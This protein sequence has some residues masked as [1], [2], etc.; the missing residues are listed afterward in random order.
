MFACTA[1]RRPDQLRKPCAGA[2][3]GLVPE[4]STTHD[5][6][7]DE[8]RVM[9][10]KPQSGTKEHIMAEEIKKEKIRRA[11]LAGP[12]CITSEATVAEMDKDGNMTVLRPGTNEWVCVPGDQNIIG[13]TDMCLDPMGMVWMKDLM[14]GKP[15]PTNTLAW[16]DLH[17]QWR[18]ATQLHRSIRPDQSRN[19]DRPA[20]DAHLAVRLR[21]PPGSAPSCGTAARWSCSPVRHTPICTFAARPGT[22]TNISLATEP[23]GP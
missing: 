5:E 7:G 11:M 16:T 12:S 13:A 22:G 6:E 1:T 2:G 17:A 8:R 10:N 19:P 21:R 4:A 3:P 9:E 14:A 15:K 20:L 23:C 18:N